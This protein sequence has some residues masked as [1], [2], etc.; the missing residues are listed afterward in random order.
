TTPD[1]KAVHGTHHTP[2][3]LDLPTYPFQRKRYW[4]PNVPAA[5]DMASVGLGEVDHPLLGAAVTRPDSEELLF[6]G[7]LSLRTHPWLGDHRVLD[8]V[9]L[10]GTAFVELGLRAGGE[11]LAGHLEELT[12]EAPLVLPESGAAPLHLA[13]GVPDETGRRS[14]TVHSRLEGA[15]SEHAWT[16]HAS[17]V[18]AS[19][20]GLPAGTG[21]TA[22]P[23][24]GAEQVDL[25]GRYDALAEQGFGYGPAF[26]GLRAVWRRGN[27]VF[28]ELSL[29]ESPVGDAQ[30]FGLHPALLDSALHAI[31]LG[32]LP[33]T[34][35]PRLPFSWSGVRLYAHGASAARVRLAPAG[36]DAVTIEVWDT[37]GAPVAS[38]ESLAVRAVS[39][40]QISAA[41]ARTHDAL[42]RVEWVPATTATGPTTEDI[43]GATVVQLPTGEPVHDTVHTA[44]AHAQQW[45]AED[46]PDH[47]RLVVV[48]HN[49]M[50]TTPDEDT[51]NLPGAAAWGL[52]RTAQTEN[53]DRVILLDLDHPTS[54][55]A[56]LPSV[57]A[58]SENQL[59]L[60]DG[61]LVTPRLARVT[62]PEASEAPFD[63]EGTVLITGATGALGGLLARHLITHH[64]TRHLLLVSR[65]GNNAPGAQQL[66][67]QLTNLGAHI[68]LAACDVTDPTALDN[69]LD[70]I[71]TAHP[72]TAVIHAA[73]I[74][75][76]G[77]FTTLTPQRV[78][79]VLS[80]KTDA[81]WNLHQATRHHNLTT[82]ALFSSIQ[83]LVGG[84][85]Q[86]NYAAANAYLDALAHHRR[87]LGLPAVS[88]AWGPWA[89]GGMAAALS[90]AGRNRF[91]RTGMVAITPDRGM[92]LF[93]TAL[94]LDLAGVVPLPLDSAALRARGPEL[95]PLMRGLVRAPV[96][97]AMAGNST[98]ATEAAGPAL[99]RRLSGLSPEDQEQLLT[100]L[101]RG[102]V[103]ATLEYSGSEAVDGRRGF[104]ELGID[105]LTAVELRNRLNKTTGLRLPATL[106]F[107][108]PSPLAVAQLLRTELDNTAG[109]GAPA[110]S[111]AADSTADSDIRRLLT[112]LSVDRLR[113]S[114][115][116]E[117]LLKLAGPDGHGAGEASGNGSAENGAEADIDIDI[118]ELDVDALVQMARES[119][120]S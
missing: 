107:D 27:E 106:V 69:L 118:D 104:K 9:L 72:L 68:T 105:S 112:T 46:R 83:G 117:G 47:E 89:E 33:G 7:R 91:A 42:F 100:D 78:S 16:R 50:A 99:A 32:V 113:G 79:T 34:G 17:G 97:R 103:A 102:E 66:H 2:Q 44:L 18:L 81:A 120:G 30:A 3:V 19:E 93:D 95:P 98:A 82:F 101:V 22:W 63:P 85:G 60:R 15:E 76:D 115:L 73:G 61:K 71:P 65:R 40:D 28:A 36:T 92:E 29:P 8:R 109:A 48:T 49:A 84:A 88:L 51:H 31:E 108:Y 45:L 87:S 77:I 64:G 58:C 116:L 90:E 56:L 74:L 59:A 37:S 23:P 96:R 110:A 21:L 39:A 70:T 13:V 26:Q 41:G 119:L 80:P 111:S 1:W 14:L 10:P 43:A 57:L 75:D 114:G 94:R 62:S 86:A 53:P 67:D 20:D 38:V 11:A 54:L 24:P 25:T 5:T 4:Q 35:E 12:L 6:T 55:D 52:L